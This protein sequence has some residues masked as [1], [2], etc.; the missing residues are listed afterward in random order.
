MRT[1][2]RPPLEGGKGRRLIG[3]RCLEPAHSVTAHSG[4]RGGQTPRTLVS[5][6]LGLREPVKSPKGAIK[7]IQGLARSDGC[8]QISL[9]RPI[10]LVTFHLWR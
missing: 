9:S 7:N 6:T 8:V 2:P 3:K 5:V 4:H 10:S 1:S